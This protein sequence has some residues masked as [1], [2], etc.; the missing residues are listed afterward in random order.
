VQARVCPAA[1]RAKLCASLY[2]STMFCM[3]TLWTAWLHSGRSTACEPM[4]RVMDHLFSPWSVVTSHGQD[5]HLVSSSSAGPAISEIHGS[6]LKAL[7]QAIENGSGRQRCNADTRVIQQPLPQTV[8]RSPRRA[9]L[10]CQ[11]ESSGAALSV[12]IRYRCKPAHKDRTGL[13]CMPT[14]PHGGQV[15]G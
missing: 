14:C 5:M 2:T 1:G 3:S 15:E 10:A 13:G 7:R 11:G 9:G 6:P 12:E 4:G 8:H